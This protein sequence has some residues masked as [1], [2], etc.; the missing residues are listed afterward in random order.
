MPA[1]LVP[2][3]TEK[4]FQRQVIQLAAH[5]GWEPYHTYDSRRS[6]PGFPDLVL[7]HPKRGLLFVELKTDTGRLT[8][9]QDRWRLVLLRAGADVRVWRPRDWDEIQATLTGVQK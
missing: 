3:L 5:C 2:K 4:Q 8:K 1:K 9:D 6:Q 7:A